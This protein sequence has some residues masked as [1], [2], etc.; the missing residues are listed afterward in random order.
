MKKRCFALVFCLLLFASALAEFDLSPYTY[1]SNSVLP[2]GGGRILTWK[3]EPLSCRI[4]IFENATLLAELN[5]EKESERQIISPYVRPDG[6]IALLYRFFTNGTPDKMVI[7][8]N[9]LTPQS[10]IDVEKNQS[11]QTLGNGFMTCRELN[12]TPY[13]V[14]MDENMN[15]LQAYPFHLR[16]LFL[17]DCAL[18]SGGRRAVVLAAQ[19]EKGSTEDFGLILAV[20]SPDGQ[21]LW[22]KKMSDTLL[23]NY[24]FSLTETTGGTLI[25]TAV[26]LEN[27]KVSHIFGFSQ[28]GEEKWHKILSGDRL[29]VNIDCGQTVSDGVQ[30]YGRCVANS[31]RIYEAMTLV[32]DDD[33][34]L[35]STAF[36]DFST[37]QD[38]KFRVLLAPDGKPYVSR[39]DSFNQE[40][41][42][43]ILV[44]LDALPDGTSREIVLE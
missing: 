44:P 16:S 30:L 40:N 17:Y 37:P 19:P 12:G 43:T 24:A 1:T 42:H 36:K 20:F 21:M 8:D 7:L 25:F 13:L 32:V 4:D 28:K 29:V 35:K 5:L 10:S 6:R 23:S 22:Q 39:S 27:Y 14:F 38:Y 15:H 9:S 18:L 3:D 31:R 2:M 41:P 11:I 26:D 34:N 33:G